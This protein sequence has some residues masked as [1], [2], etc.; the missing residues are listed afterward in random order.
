M[1]LFWWFTNFYGIGVFGNFD[2]CPG[3]LKLSSYEK[4]SFCRELVAVIVVTD[5]VVVIVVVE[6]VVVVIAI[7]AAGVDVAADGVANVAEFSSSH[8]LITNRSIFRKL[9]G[10]EQTRGGRLSCKVHKG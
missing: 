10:E 4:T 8:F 5:V 3:K 9:S 1:V 2:P 7:I 6:V